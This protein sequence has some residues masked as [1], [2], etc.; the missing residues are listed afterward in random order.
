M[1]IKKLPTEI[2]TQ[3][4][5]K[6][7]ETNST[8]E[9]KPIKKAKQVFTDKVHSFI[10]KYNIKPGENPVLSKTLYKLFNLEFPEYGIQRFTRR[11]K[12]LLPFDTIKKN[13]LFLIDKDILDISK[14][15]EKL[16]FKT[17]NKVIAKKRNYKRHIEAYI[18]FFKLSPGQ[19]AISFIILDDL[20]DRWTYK[21][22]KKKIFGSL[23]K[24]L[25]MY[26]PYQMHNKALYFLVN[27]EIFK[28]VSK[29]QLEI[30]K[31]SKINEQK[32]KD[33]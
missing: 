24:L 7:L 10:S 3:D 27:N 29:R 28:V 13:T 14:S 16:V 18:K 25:K 2:D 33:N 9:L 15:V 32:E 19:N 30:I 11:M 12:Y 17:N 4:L 26:L 22:K 1:K 8:I 20:Y 5:L 23:S 6:L 31:K 21:T